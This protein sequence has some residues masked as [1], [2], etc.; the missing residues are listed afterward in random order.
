[1]A[2]RMSYVWKSELG[3]D[4]A[5]VEKLEGTGGKTC[6]TLDRGVVMKFEKRGREK[7]VPIVLDAIVGRRML[8]DL[9]KFSPEGRR[10]DL[11]IIGNGT[12][13]FGD[14]KRSAACY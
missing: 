4:V 12:V 5:T 3:L 8:K 2:S 10:E 7:P 11:S 9:K 1:M 14:S 13:N 6:G